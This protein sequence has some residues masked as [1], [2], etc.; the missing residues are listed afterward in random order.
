VSQT[1][2]RSEFALLTPTQWKVTVGILEH[3]SAVKFP[4][5]KLL[6]IWI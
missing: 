1:N 2:N 4:W 3:V 5:I 6:L